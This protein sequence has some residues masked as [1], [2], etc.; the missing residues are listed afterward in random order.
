LRFTEDDLKNVLKNPAYKVQAETTR[1]PEKAKTQEPEKRSKYGNVKT[2]EKGIRFDSKKEAARYQELMLL[3]QA[4]EIEELRLQETF[5]L[6]NAY[7]TTEGERIKAI[8]YRADFTYYEGP[9]ATCATIEDCKG[10]MTNEFRIK[11]KM[12]KSHFP[13][14]IYKLT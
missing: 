4:G 7:T 6:Q 3:E 10:K 9:L 2:T 12:M 14:F 5:V 8:T 11:W 13:N 1:T